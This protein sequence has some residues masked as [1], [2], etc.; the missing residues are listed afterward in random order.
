MFCLE[1][2]QLSGIAALLRFPMEELD[3][4]ENDSSDED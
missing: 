3:E 1:L 4:V 2:D